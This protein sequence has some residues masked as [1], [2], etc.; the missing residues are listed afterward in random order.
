MS[1]SI[2]FRNVVREKLLILVG[3]SDDIM[4]DINFNKIIEILFF[5]RI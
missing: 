3:N 4:V 5:K 1:R 2:S